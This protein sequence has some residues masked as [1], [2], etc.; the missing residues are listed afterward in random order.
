MHILIADDDPVSLAR[1]E[2]ALESWQ[3][4]PVA[5]AN[6]TDAL[7]ALKADDSPSIAVLDWQ[8]PGVNGAEVCR[9]ARRENARPLH[10]ILLTATRTS[11]ED[12]LAGL[13]CGADDFVAKPFD[14]AELRAR[15]AIGERIV[16]LQTE[17]LNRIRE[18]AASLEHIRQLEGLLPICAWCK[19]IQDDEA[20]WQPIESYF[21]KRSEVEFTHSICPRCAK[22]Q[23]PQPMPDA[24]PSSPPSP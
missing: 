20:K 6:G 17:L 7:A 1:L 5:F 18:L 11:R 22:R 8:M 14:P 23:F 16:N 3:H 21:S 9:Q 10:L 19:N 13:A 15:L 2:H 24:T 12:R 4:T